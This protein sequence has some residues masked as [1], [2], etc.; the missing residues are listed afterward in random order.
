VR[1]LERFRR[2]DEDTVLR[3]LTRP[4]RDGERGGEPER[5]GAGDD[6]HCDRGDEREDER[7]R[8]SD[9]EPDDEGRDREED[10]RGHEVAG[11]EVGEALDRRLRALR[12]LDQMDDLGE[13]RVL[14]DAGRPEAEGARLVD[15][16]PD[17]GVP[18]LLRHRDRL[19]RDHRLVDRR[20]TLDDLA[21]NGDLL[22][23]ANDYDVS[24]LDLLD[25]HFL[26]APV[27]KDAGRSGLEADELPDRLARSRLRPRLDQAPEHDQGEDDADDLVVDLAQVL[28][29]GTG[30]ERDD[31]AV[32]EGGRRPD[33]DERVHVGR[34]VAKDEPA[35][36]VDGPARVDHD[37]GRESELEP[38]VHEDSG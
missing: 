6:E 13:H 2:T 20:A 14:A 23:G 31:E 5:A 32:E 36:S 37:G 28:G 10:D 9:V 12:L 8:R 35:G 18:R 29:E 30:N 11:D 4:D 26:L 16:R 25:R 38:A 33:R 1:R 15:R 21:V 3:S 7:R 27:A 22:A 34:A 19:A 24:P 17:D